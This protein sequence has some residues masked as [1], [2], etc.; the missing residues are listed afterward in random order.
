[1][2]YTYNKKLIIDALGNPRYSYEFEKLIKKIM[3]NNINDS[4]GIYIEESILNVEQDTTYNILNIKKQAI[5]FFKNWETFL[6]WHNIAQYNYTRYNNDKKTFYIGCEI[7]N[8]NKFLI[9]LALSNNNKLEK[10]QQLTDKFT[11][12]INNQIPFKNEVFENFILTC[13]KN[14]KIIV[15]N[16]TDIH[17]EK[18]NNLII[19]K[20]KRFEFKRID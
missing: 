14:G 7:Y 18:I 1:M 12:K 3:R 19:L 17:I 20:N 16:L 6:I 5:D 13:Y 2:D 9:M 11:T 15:K 8:L 4:L 10:S